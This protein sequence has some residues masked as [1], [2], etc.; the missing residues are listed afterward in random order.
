MFLFTG[1]DIHIIITAVFTN[2]LPFIDL[3]ARNDEHIP[4]FLRVA[5]TV[6]CSFAVFKSNQ[7]ASCT[8]GDLAFIISITC[9]H[10][11]HNTVTFSICQELVTETN[12]SAGGDHKFHTQIAG[13]LCHV[14]QFSL[15]QSQPFHNSSH[16][17]LRNVNC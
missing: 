10:M 5:Y 14:S 17:F 1:I 6:G 12:K 11:I 8:S 7:A 13:H 9:E 16:K 4:A 3:F 15:T 2:D